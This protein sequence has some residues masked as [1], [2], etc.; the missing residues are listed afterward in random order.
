MQDLGRGEI[1]VP[2]CQ[3]VLGFVQTVGFIE[4]FCGASFHISQ[5]Y[6]SFCRMVESGWRSSGT[7]G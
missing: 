6:L 7:V 3:C 4:V 5:A 1:T 2:L